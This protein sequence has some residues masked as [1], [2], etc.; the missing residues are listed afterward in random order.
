MYA[1]SLTHK[2][3]PPQPLMSETPEVMDD[4]TVVSVV[5]HFWK[6]ISILIRIL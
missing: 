4:L 1:E 2:A 3:E 6:K 5:Y